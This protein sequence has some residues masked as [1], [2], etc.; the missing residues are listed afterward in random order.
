M[1]TSLSQIKGAS[2]PQLPGDTVLRVDTAED[3]GVVI[4]DLGAEQQEIHCRLMFNAA[5]ASGGTLAFAGGIDALGLSAWQVVLDLDAQVVSAHA[6]QTQVSAPLSDALDWH[7]VEVGLDAIT[8]LL[9][10]RLNGIERASAPAALR[11]T[12]YAWLGGAFQ[13]LDINGHVDLDQWV[14]ATEPIGVPRPTPSQ[15][16]AGDPR[17]WLVVYNRSDADSRAWASIYRERRSVPYANLCGLDL[18]SDET[19]SAAAYETMRQQINDYLD[20]NGLRQRIVG[21]LLGYRVP[22][23]ADVASQGALTPITSYLQTDDT[24]GQPV[25]SPLYQSEITRR[26]SANDYANARLTG[27]IDAPTLSEAIALIDRADDLIANPLAHDQGADLIIDI[28][29]DNPN[30]SPGY[31]LPVDEWANGFGLARLRLPATI[32]DAQAPTSV[33][34][35]AV[36]WGWRDAAP[37]P[38]FFASSPGRRAICMQFDPAPD[39]AD[40]VRDAGATHWL[41]AALQAGYAFAAAPSRAYSLSS[42]PLPRLFFEAIRLGWTVAEAWLVAQPFLRDGLQIIGDPLAS[43]PL[44]KAGY[45]VFGP[46]SRLDQIDLD[47][48]LAVLHAGEKRLALQADELPEQDGSARY[49]VRAVDDKGR[50]D[51]ASSSAIVAI[52]T[53]EVIRPV[54][55]AWPIHDGWPVLQ[56]GGQLVLTAYWPASLRSLGVDSVRLEAL[57]ASDQTITHSEVAPVT[58]QR[59]V[60]F[61]IDQPT[62]PTKYR[63]TSTQGPANIHTPWSSEVLPAAT[64]DQSLTVLEVSL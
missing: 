48:P 55:P 30:V 35:E 34:N 11:P 58:G 19:I 50:P 2:P 37:P 64:L 6:E 43:I 29:P 5:Q 51:F 40:S 13:S 23:Y 18:S 52:E 17:R 12:R 44:P 1:T 60:A 41:S 53:G 24:H 57:G 20:D 33:S 7:C 10:L 42:L 8:G 62:E 22:G 9:T 21:V 63:F 16:H 39:P 45:D 46:V 38:G 26:P 31:T 27:R 54:R 3:A 49:L 32:Y 59:R 28:N 4:H 36:V 25:V 15:D 47:R 14:L 61:V 56:R